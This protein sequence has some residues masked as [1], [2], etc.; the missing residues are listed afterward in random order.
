M[1]LC[2]DEQKVRHL[3]EEKKASITRFA[4]ELEVSPAEVYQKFKA[5]SGVS[6]KQLNTLCIYFMKGEEHILTEES[7]EDLDEYRKD[8]EFLDT[9]NAQY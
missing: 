3:L 1:K 2:L 5:K 8:M 9:L 4:R 7:L 6:I